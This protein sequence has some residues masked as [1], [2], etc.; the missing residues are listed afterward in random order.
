[1]SHAFNTLSD[2]CHKFLSVLNILFKHSI[3][4]AAP[5]NNSV[6]MSEERL[7]KPKDQ[8]MFHLD[9]SNYKHSILK[10]GRTPLSADTQLGGP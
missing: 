4:D 7:G 10:C 8:E 3:I 9:N 1:M 5:K 2:C 6:G